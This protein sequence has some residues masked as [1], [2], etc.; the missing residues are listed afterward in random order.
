MQ[1]SKSATLAIIIFVYIYGL[2]SELI[3]S[4]KFKNLYLYIINPLVWVV[5]AIVLR[6]ILGKNIEN[7][8]LRKDIIQYALIAVLVYI[9]TYMISGLFITFGKN[10]Y[11]RTIKGVLINIWIFGSVIIAKEYIRFK[12]INNVYEKDKT[13]IAVLILIIYILLEIQVSKFLKN[14]LNIIFIITY[15]AQKMIPLVAKNILYS[16]IAMK[17]GFAASVCYELL[18]NLYLWLSPILP[19]SPWVMEAIIN[20]SIPAILFLYI[21]YENNKNNYLIDRRT[22]I[23][24]NPKNIIPLV[25]SIILVIWFALGIFPIKPVAIASGSM[26][27]E[28]FVG[29]VVIIKKS[30]P[31]DIIIGDIIEYQMDG[32]SVIH[33]VIDKR[34]RNKE[35][36]YTTKGD[37]NL[38][39][40]DKE[41][42]EN[43]ITRKSN[44]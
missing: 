27:K 37:N 19:N 26:E 21:R 14:D 5:I 43:Q 15:S 1:K 8:K 13:K 20:T 36:Y 40:D 2:I 44:I 29:D 39:K 31:E 24:T 35:Y 9:I 25:V 11:S 12:L 6:Q 28:L 42:R 16:Y 7:R 34:Q 38:K 18:T 41:V 3:L 10:P 4:A 30:K 23:D 32:Y 22:L 17:K 33:R